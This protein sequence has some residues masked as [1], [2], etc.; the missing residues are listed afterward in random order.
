MSSGLGADIAAVVAE[1]RALSEDELMPD[2]YAIER[3]MTRIP[4]GSGGYTEEPDVVEEGHCRLSGGGRMGSE[5]VTGGVV[6]A[7]GPYVVHLPL[8]TTLKADDTIIVNGRRFEVVET[9]ERAGAWAITVKAS[10]E[11]RST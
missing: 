4:D 2:E 11:E 3:G 10:L 6:T 9:P 8:S 5:G 7:T 1:M